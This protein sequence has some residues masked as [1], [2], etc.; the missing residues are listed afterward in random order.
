[1]L[2]PLARMTI[3]PAPRGVP[4]YAIDPYTNIA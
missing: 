4:Q 3:R 2:N 1:M